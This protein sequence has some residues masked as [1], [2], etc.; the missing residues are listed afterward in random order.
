MIRGQLETWRIYGAPPEELVS[1]MTKA[2]PSV[3]YI[4]TVFSASRYKASVPFHC[5]AVESFGTSTTSLRSATRTH[6]HPLHQRW[7]DILS[8]HSLRVSHLSSESRFGNALFLQHV[9]CL[10]GSSDPRVNMRQTL[11]LPP[12]STFVP[13]RDPFSYPATRSL[14]SPQS[15]ILPSL[16]ISKSIQSSSTT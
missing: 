12:Y 8:S 1:R 6:P 14:S 3:L 16:S 15:T 2:R 9:W 11:R 5:G 7:T 13:N 10:F 4:F